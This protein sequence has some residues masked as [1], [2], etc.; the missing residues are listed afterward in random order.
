MNPWQD[1]TLNRRE[2]VCP[3]L[4]RQVKRMLLLGR[5]E[6]GERLPSRRETAAA[7]EVNPNTVQK[8]YKQLEEEGII[9]TDGNQGSIV[10]CSPET[11]SRMEGELTRGMAAEFV[12]SAKEL[13]LSFK[14][15]VDLLS[16]LWEEI[17]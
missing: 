1:L 14:Q 10:H 2:P 17:R 9:L 13:H 8:A 4:V 6:N 3:Q 12:T 15:T 16:G 7:L 5:L 11:Y